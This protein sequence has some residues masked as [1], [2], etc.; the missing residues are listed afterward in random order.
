MIACPKV[1]QI[2][3]CLFFCFLF[4]FFFYLFLLPFSF[5]EAW[6]IDMQHINHRYA[7]LSLFMLFAFCVTDPEIGF[8]LWFTLEFVLGSS[9][10]KVKVSPCLK[11]WLKF[12]FSSCYKKKL[13]KNANMVISK[14]SI[15]QICVCPIYL[16][17]GVNICL[18]SIVALY[19]QC[20][21]NIFA[22]YLQF[23]I[24][25]HYICNLQYIC[26]QVSISISDAIK[27]RKRIIFSSCQICK[28]FIKISFF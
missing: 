6:Q 19:L 15:S 9:S 25:L 13:C 1:E 11:N 14:L 28:V 18:R 26:C 10:L 21:R 27:N 22:I 4:A 23:A 20:I 12:E 2:K 5:A 16:L 3:F 7:P 24:Y 8:H 17:P